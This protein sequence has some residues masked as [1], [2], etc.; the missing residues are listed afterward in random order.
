MKGSVWS[1]VHQWPRSLIVNL[2]SL[3]ARWEKQY[4]DPIPMIHMIPLQVEWNPLSLTH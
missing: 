1:I 2:T 3:E 4:L